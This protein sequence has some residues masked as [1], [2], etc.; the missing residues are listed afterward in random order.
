MSTYTPPKSWNEINLKTFQQLL[1][2]LL[3]NHEFTR[4]QY[5]NYMIRLSKII[6]VPDEHIDNMTRDE[7][8]LWCSNLQ[9]LHSLPQTLNF[10]VNIDG[11]KYSFSDNPATWHVNEFV[12]F[13]VYTNDRTQDEVLQELHNIVAIFLR[14]MKR[15]WS[16]KKFFKGLIFLNFNGYEYGMTKYV[17]SEQ[18]ARAKVFQEK[19]PAD[20]AYSICLFF[21]LI[22][23]EYTNNT[24]LSS[25][26][27]LLAEVQQD[28]NSSST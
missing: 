28:S 18:D 17:S 7:F 3:P 25:I 11:V 4:I 24:L 13:G 10:N 8:E 14:P 5:Q 6:G 16:W 22:V 2:H 26:Q 1:P 23:N 21:C 19:L 9:W 20:V 12:D 27:H 15:V